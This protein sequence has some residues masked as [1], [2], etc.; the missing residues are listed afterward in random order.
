MLKIHISRINNSVLISKDEFEKIIENLEK[1]EKVEIESN[2][3][4]DLQEASSSSLEFWNN[5]IYDRVWNDA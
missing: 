5:E 3:F 4:K 1:N 2:E